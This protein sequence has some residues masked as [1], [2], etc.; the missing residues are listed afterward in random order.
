MTVLRSWQQLDSLLSVFNRM[1]D[2]L[3]VDV[4]F[5]IESVQPLEK[6]R[7]GTLIFFQFSSTHVTP[8]D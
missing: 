3:K 5:C 4:A 7:D 2:N 6:P 1:D 8:G